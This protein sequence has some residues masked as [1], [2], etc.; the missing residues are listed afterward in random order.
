MNSKNNVHEIKCDVVIVVSREWTCSC[1]SNKFR[2]LGT[3]NTCRVWRAQ[4]QRGTW[5]C[6]AGRRRG[7]RHRQWG[8]ARD[9]G[10]GVDDGNAAGKEGGSEREFDTRDNDGNDVEIVEGGAARNGGE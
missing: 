9:D 10:A 1:Y 8:E 2:F 5:T 6:P 3:R 7:E 4:G